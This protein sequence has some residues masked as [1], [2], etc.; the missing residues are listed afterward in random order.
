MGYKFQIS[1]DASPGILSYM[2]SQIM[3]KAILDHGHRWYIRMVSRHLHRPGTQ[4]GMVCT[5]FQRSDIF[6]QHITDTL[7]LK[8]QSIL[9]NLDCTSNSRHPTQKTQF[10]T[11]PNMC[12]A[13]L[14]MIVETS[15]H[16]R[17]YNLY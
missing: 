1:Q 3:C 8:I 12:L 16:H 14:L 10:N 7:L 5:H 15:W 6:L 11:N 2:T 17:G 9:Y 4:F 13:H